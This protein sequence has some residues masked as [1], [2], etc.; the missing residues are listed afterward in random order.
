MKRRLALLLAL[1]LLLAGG[2]TSSRQDEP[3]LWLGPWEYALA[4]PAVDGN[5]D[6]HATEKPWIEAP[7]G[8]HEAWFRIPAH[9]DAPD[10]TLYVGRTPRA[11]DVSCDDRPIY[12][13]PAA[14][15]DAPAHWVDL[16]T[17]AGSRFLVLHSPELTRKH[18][19]LWPTIAVGE[20]WRLWS[21]VMRTTSPSFV[22]ALLFAAAG[23]MG[24]AAH[25]VAESRRG[26]LY[27]AFGVLA[28]IQGLQS[29]FRNP[30]SAII[31]DSS[32]AA[33]AL[34]I[35]D[36]LVEAAEPFYLRHMFVGRW[37]ER[38]LKLA[39]A[40][41]GLVALAIAADL[42]LAQGWWRR[43]VDFAA[44]GNFVYSLF[45]STL[46]A[47]LMWRARGPMRLAAFG[48]LFFRASAAFEAFFVFLGDFTPAFVSDYGFL[49][50][51]VFLILSLLIVARDV[52]ARDVRAR[53]EAAR[54]AAIART[55]QMLAHDVRKPFTLLR[56]I[57]GML[58]DAQS[59]DEVNES[60]RDFLPE[61]DGALASVNGMIQD[62]MEI[63]SDRPP[64]L[65]PVRPEALVHAALSELFAAR[66]G[67]DVVLEYALGRTTAIDIDRL[68]VLRVFQNILGN[69]LEAMHGKGRIWIRTRE[70]VEDAGRFV[71]FCLGNSGTFIAQ[72]DVPKLFNAFFTKGKA[73]GTGLGLA[74]AKKIVNAHGGRIWCRSSREVGVE[75]LFTLP[76]ANGE[77]PSVVL[78]LP[79]H[80]RELELAHHPVTAVRE[81]AGD[82]EVEREAMQRLQALGR[83]ARVLI[84]DDESVYVSALASFVARGSALDGVCE[85]YCAGSA[86][87]VKSITGPFNPDLIIL[88]V[89][90]E[91]DRDGGYKV[92]RGLRAAGQDAIICM[93][94]NRNQISDHKAAIA[95]GA[96]AFMPKPMTKAHF[97]RL[98]AQAAEK[99]VE[100]RGPGELPWIDGRLSA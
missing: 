76:C 27:M 28:C 67:T 44:A 83:P 37:T 58:R 9:A 64:T 16:R 47:R 95:S 79:H 63:G 56:M 70:V 5:A 23:L 90:L 99:A 26:S 48:L 55:T 22:L 73:S 94:S 87:Q 15:R 8:V 46:A 43:L 30:L 71:E 96:D 33:V 17:C 21:H 72:D 81:A 69:A 84:V 61:V 59:M 34:L 4:P 24:I 89:D 74:I 18:L 12:K 93:H 20:R 39:T 91:H 11:F 82:A 13:F 68:K 85:V 14:K 7:P 65:A 50:W 19:G 75:F 1:S 2:C 38:G 10:A 25:F 40:F 45:I 62:V 3:G 53:L 66:V 29:A 32:L 41:F 100:G 51:M 52:R 97:L 60:V 88:D 36:P 54:T 57:M 77:C 86:Q 35:L 49:A 31:F 42:A 98:L 92:A 80:S 78:S 6:W